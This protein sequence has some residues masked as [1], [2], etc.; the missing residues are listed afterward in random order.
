[1][2][3]A[4]AGGGGSRPSGGSSHHSMHS[5]GST[6]HVSSHRPTSSP[7]HSSRPSGGGL[8]SSGHNN[9][10]SFSH[11]S[12]PISNPGMFT[13]PVSHKPQRR[14]EPRREQ[15]PV[16]HDPPRHEPPRHREPPRQ[17]TVI[18]NNTQPRYTQ[19]ST[20]TSPS[21]NTGRVY[22][23]TGSSMLP[24]QPPVRNVRSD[25]EFRNFERRMRRGLYMTIFGTF[26]LVVLLLLIMSSSGGGNQKSTIQ[27]EKLTDVPM[28]LNDCVIDEL[29]WI[30]N[31]TRLASN[32][33]SFYDETGMQPFIYMRAYDPDLYDDEDMEWFASEWFED[34]LYAKGYTNALLY[35][36]FADEDQDGVIGPMVIRYGQR[37]SQ[38]MDAEAESIFW[39]YLDAKWVQ[40]DEDHTDEMFVDIFNSTA[41]TIMRVSTTGKDIIKWVLI[42]FVVCAGVGGAIIIIVK[43]RQ[44]E[45][46]R[47]EETER[48]LN[49]SMD[50]LVK[51][52]ADKDLLDKY[53]GDSSK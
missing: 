1:M 2:G 19:P 6:H 13:P 20:Y 9:G 32:L 16:R 41:K 46:E 49:T 26:F 43:K 11:K 12:S 38:I 47:A 15:P 35:I 39:K 27:R 4:G 40:Y 30:N 17:T 44:A 36:Y 7:S 23:N 52:Q 21:V 18:I 53:S 45:K 34:N 10:P 42:L 33:K 14:E 5:S 31:P 29:G 22:Q 48:I 51:T 50:D 8:K 3:R 37:A 28:Y 25:A 24:P